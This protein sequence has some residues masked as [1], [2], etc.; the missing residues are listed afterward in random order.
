LR[1][2]DRLT[3]RLRAWLRPHL[4]DQILSEELAFHIERQIQANIEAGMTPAQ[5]RR[6]AHVAVGS[7]QAIREESRESRPG[8]VL[9]QIVRDLVYGTRILRKAPG[10]AATSIVIVALGIGAATAIFSVVYGVVLRP[11]P[12]EEPGRLVSLWTMMPKLNMQ[13]A[14]VNAADY[15]DWRA[16]NHVFEDIALVR[17]VANFN[18]IGAGEPERLFGARVSP[19][20]FKVLGVTPALGRTFTEEED[21]YG[22]NTV[23]LLSDGLWRRR[24][25]ADRSIVGATI[26]LS[27]IPHTV[28]GVMR[29]DFQYPG[30][31]F[32]IWTPLT[33]DPEILSRKFPGYDWL[34]VARLKRGVNLA[35]AQAEMDGIAKRLANAYPTTNPQTGVLV[36]PLLESTVGAARPAL[37]AVFGAV[38]CMVV[39]ACLNLASLL[40]ARMASRSREFAVRLALGASRGRLALQAVAEVAPVL[41]VGGVLGV[42]AAA[43]GVAAFVP[44]APTTLPRVES[45]G[46]NGPV[47]AFSIVMLVATGL[48]AALLPAVQAWRLELTNATREDSRSSFGSPRQ[49][50]T[51]NYLVVAQ[52]AILVPLL[53]GAGLLVRSFSAVV[54]VD[55]GFRAEHVLSLNM[56]I[57][58]SKYPKDDQ[59]AGFV[60]QVVERVASLPG[61]R[62][63]GMVNR[64]PLAG[65]AQINELEFEAV[66]QPSPTGASVRE[67]FDTR[68][69]TPDYFQTM[70]IRLIEGRPFTDHDTQVSP[71]PGM[72]GVLIPAT[73]IVDD[74]IARRF[75][76]G[77]SAVGKRFRFTFLPGPPW[78]EIVGVAGH[79]RHDGLDVDPRPQVYFNY[80]QRPQDRMALVVRT[81]QD[82][83][84]LI[85]ATL[86]AIRSVD[87]EQPVYDVRTMED[88]VERSTAQRWLNTTMVTVFAAIALLLASVGVYGVVAYGVSER[89]REF[90][91]RL[92]LGAERA[93]VARLVV[94]QGTVLAIAGSAIGFLAAVFV[95][96]AIESL[97]YGIRASDPP[98]FATAVGLLVA[99]ALFASYL[100]ARRA[101][102]VD[103]AITLRSE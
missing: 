85:S 14:N 84:A 53:V 82:P 102:S 103:P 57:P 66:G 60:G 10:F 83:R 47:L 38:T 74:R 68:T 44:L 79:I 2:F 23:A 41:L 24:F 52:M 91:I 87:S 69:V 26:N 32:Q 51:R 54:S 65:G 92:A 77:E 97:L 18:L 19:N 96:K 61:V 31:E 50:R 1:A 17:H 63:A 40:G 5:A 7:V 29:P 37:Y 6:A 39:I 75:W 42:A 30:R 33:V 9:R 12:Y 28:V 36:E 43:W 59:V 101:A 80:L 93:A 27:G 95:A 94:W 15:R 64:L 45:I 46:V 34:A 25:G 49:S 13:R 62:S 48:V 3:V 98:S 8:A 67:G 35:Q 99:V 56:A 89:R 73:G 88:V 100:P 70:G 55:P 72:Q 11:L 76:P 78:I 20:L 16:D 81:N 58:R 90:G 71:V 4:N 86:D 21:E 22:R